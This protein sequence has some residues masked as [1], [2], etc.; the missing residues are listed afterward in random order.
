MVASHALLGYEGLFPGAPLTRLLR[1]V[2]DSTWQPVYMP[3]FFVITGFCTTWRRAFPGFL[4][5]NVRSLKVP[6]LVF[7]GLAGAFALR[8]V[9][10]FPKLSPYWWGLRMMET[11]F[12]FVHALFLAKLLYWPMARYLSLR[13]RAAAAAVAYA[14]GI[15]GLMSVAHDPL[16][17]LHALALLPFLLMGDALKG[18]GFRGRPAAACALAFAA[19]A[20][21]LTASGR[22]VPYI[23]QAVG[24]PAWPEAV[25]LPALAATGSYALLYLCRRRD[26]CRPVEWLGRYSLVV[27]L[28]HGPELI[29]LALD[30]LPSLYGGGGFAALGCNLIVRVTLLA[31]L[32]AAAGWA[33][34]R[35]WLRVA[36]GKRP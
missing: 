4:W 32:C 16:W 2:A 1:A 20:A 19:V 28:L 17:T 12:W 6:V 29:G 7:S 14:A 3:A 30:A 15:G 31:A 10:G 22:G 25:A 34:D 27:Y 33:L 8:P 13:L 18:F 24:C 9:L 36:I 35:P 23:T 21:A 26:A 5:A 11:A